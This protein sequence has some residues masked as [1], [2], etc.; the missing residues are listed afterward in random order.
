MAVLNAWQKIDRVLTG[1][2]FGDGS[3]GAYSSATIPTLTKDSC[4]ISATS[5]TLTTAGSTFANGDVL[6]IHQTGGT[7][8]GQ[9]EINRV[10]SGGGTAT[11][12]LQVASN[13]TFTDSGASQAQAIK[14]PQYTTVT[15]QAGTWTV[16]AWDGNING[17]FTFAAKTSATITGTLTSAAKGYLKGTQQAGS[18]GT[19]QQG[20]GQAGTAAARATTANGSGG[21]G[22]RVEES[23]SNAKNS[24]GGGGGGNG[25]AG[26]TAATQAGSDNPQ[27][28]AQAG[29]TGGDA[30]GAA[31]LTTFTLGGGGGSG[32]N[33]QS[34]GFGTNGNVAGTGGGAIIV[35]AKDLQ[36][37]G[38]V[39]S[40]GEAGGTGQNGSGGGGGAGGSNL[41]VVQTA[42]LGSGVAIANAGGGAA[43]GL[44]GG[45]GGSGAT[46][47]IAVHH[48]NTVTGTT[49]P[50]FTDVSDVT[51][52]E[53]TVSGT[54][55]LTS[56]MW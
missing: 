43:Q 14:I 25:A 19:G 16:P 3:D 22:G 41:F 26:S 11:L 52:V 49:S 51:L 38:A 56:K 23:N 37:T 31:D 8:A 33:S 34:P 28:P 13:Y 17:I 10:S 2:P 29:G 40:S 15:V 39:S 4:S 55:D 6:L 35:F 53:A 36:I 1:L 44:Y 24:S 20:S 42:T 48:S 18:D 9:W 30:T 46:G 32:G 54:L 45:G 27:R 47:R 5:T 12:T 21:G 7:G 50:S